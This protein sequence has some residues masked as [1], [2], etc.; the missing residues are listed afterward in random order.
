VFKAEEEENFE[1]VFIMR[2]RGMPRI[3]NDQEEWRFAT[4]GREMSK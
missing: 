4:A 2:Q 3:D 1:R